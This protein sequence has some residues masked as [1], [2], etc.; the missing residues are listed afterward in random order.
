M[1]KRMRLPNGFGQISKINARLRKPYRA[2][3]TIGFREDGRPICKNL[4]PQAYFETYNDA[5]AALLEYNRN[6][7]ELQD[8]LTV[9]GLYEKWSKDYFET[10]KNQSSIRSIKSAWSYCSILKKMSLSALRTRHIKGCINDA[11]LIL[12]DGTKKKASV[13]TK[14]RIKSLFNNM[15][16]YAL[17]YELIEKN[18]A[19]DFKI[20][21]DILIEGRSNTKS[22]MPFSDAELDI[23]WN[24][25]SI[26]YV[27]A[28]LIQCY[29]G[30]RPQELGLIRVENVDFEKGVI[31]GGMKTEAGTNRVVP[32]HEKIKEL[33][34]SRYFE[35]KKIG[36]EYLINCDGSRMT[37]DK[38]R[39]R[40]DKIVSMLKL[41]PDH[42]PHD[43]RNT[44]V[45]RCKHFD[46]DEYAIKYIVGHAITDI[47]EKVYTQRDTSWLVT[48]LKKLK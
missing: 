9:E 14:M 25:V 36:C 4:K 42:R 13:N 24:R 20:S 2:R 23:L 11:E 27:D 29:T 31:I 44:F 39:H 30:F 3:V 22:H 28:I 37:Y 18:Y 43:G 41:H 1:S 35:A 15:L 38:Y 32:I 46:V 8:N 6:P 45:T 19:R 5:Y 47:T 7:Y 33:V 21:N 26:P 17:E 40:F 34:K 12:N 10:L 48:E 16:D